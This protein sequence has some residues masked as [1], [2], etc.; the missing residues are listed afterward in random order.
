VRQN[1]FP[2][3]GRASI[4]VVFPWLENWEKETA[5]YYTAFCAA[6]VLQKVTGKEKS[7]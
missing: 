2:V 7:R 1:P 6:G 5:G 3:A 4:V